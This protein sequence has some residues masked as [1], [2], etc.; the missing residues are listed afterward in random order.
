MDV[1]FG[2][3]SVVGF[4]YTYYWG[5]L[6]IVHALKS[7][8][9]SFIPRHVCG[10]LF[11]SIPATLILPPLIYLSD[12]KILAF[13]VAMSVLA[14]VGYIFYLVTTSSNSAQRQPVPEAVDAKEI[15]PVAPTSVSELIKIPS[16]KTPVA[17][18]NRAQK[19]EKPNLEPSSKSKSHV[20]SFIYEDAEGNISRRN[21]VNWQEDDAYF[22]GFCLDRH[23][24]RTFKKERV[25]SYLDDS[26]RLLKSPYPV[27]IHIE[28]TKQR[29]V[30]AEILFTGFSKDERA[31]LED[32]ARLNGLTVCKSATVGLNYICTGK[33][34][35]PAKLAQALA[36][37]A[38]ELSVD[39]F[40][41]LVETGEI[42]NY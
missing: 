9:Y 42:P 39:E 29:M 38:I 22:E 7:R 35:G 23:E 16:V 41:Q 28:K 1:F 6:R 20:L 17:I 26:D 19:I 3:I 32:L 40:Y 30:S 8:N 24:G 10:A 15:V 31:N 21:I 36:S 34:A 11:A 13:L 27:G 18:N 2:L 33:N 25:L 12:Q 4:F 14:T 37:G 5:W